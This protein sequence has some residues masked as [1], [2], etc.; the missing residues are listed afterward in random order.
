MEQ[1]VDDRPIIHINSPNF[2]FNITLSATF[3][4]VIFDGLNSFATFNIVER[5]FD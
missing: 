5:K 1:G 4:D 3:E 2:Y